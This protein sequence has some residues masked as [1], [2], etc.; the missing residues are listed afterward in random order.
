MIL[1]VLRGLVLVLI[2]AVSVL[3][4]T[5]NQE[6]GGISFGQFSL[7]LAITLGLAGLVIAADALS[8]KKKLSAISG[9]FIGL[10]VGLIVL[11]PL[12]YVVDLVGALSRPADPPAQLSYE[13]AL[14]QV[15]Q[16]R[17]PI[18]EQDPPAVDGP[19]EDAEP[20][21]AT[22]SRDEQARAMLD[23]NR[24]AIEEAEAAI[25]SQ[26]NLLLG[27]K[28][29]LGV[30]TCYFCISLVLQTKDDFRFII[31]Y[32]EFAKQIRGNRPAILDTSVIIDGRI[33]DVIDTQVMQGVIIVPRFVLDELQLIA[34]SNDK[35]K[36]ARG[37]RGLEVLQKLQASTIVEVHIE[38]RE[39]EGI[40]VD[41]KL[42]D[43]AHQMQGRVMTNDFNLNKIASLRGVDVININDLAKALRP[44]VLPGEHMT[45]K[46]I[47]PGES[48]TQGVGY[49]EDGTMVVVENG[50]SHLDHH[51]DLVV[52]STLQTS[53]GRMIFGRF[54][55]EED[56]AGPRGG[57]ES[58][59][60]TDD[61]PAD[62]TRTAN[63]DNPDQSS[64]P[65]P[66]QNPRKGGNGSRRNPRRG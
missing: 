63:A 22:A 58:K 10:I 47:K 43:L 12:A 5:T 35:L 26:R 38:E 36:R 25:Q 11:L 21:A 2:T 32:V 33:L 62:T 17:G 49:L 31:P 65:Y 20:D 54:A 29:V 53:A 40:N 66:P 50:R 56:E 42:I 6:Q 1:F 51:V 3:F 15:N 39:A 13:Q 34:D 64:G 16:S 7:M 18:D 52:T 9:V 59:P 24:R 27:V 46:L 57:N 8:P 60:P 19:G 23:A 55:H 37:R 45:V 61:K 41:Q 30:I 48:P 4:L 44:V 14:E 28:V